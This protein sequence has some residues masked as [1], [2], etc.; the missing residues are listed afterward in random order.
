MEIKRVILIILDGFGVGALPDAKEYK[1][2]GAN[3]LTHIYETIPDFNLPNMSALGIYK[4]ITNYKLPITN[5]ELIGSY[6]KMA[7]RSKGKDTTTGHWEISG[8]ILEEPFPT[9]PNGFPKE[10]IDSY[11][12]LIGKKTIG[13]FPCSGTEILKLLGEEHC[14]TGYPIIYTSADS[15]FQIAENET[16]VPLQELYKHCEIAREMLGN[17]PFEKHKVGRVIA[18]PFVGNSKENF[19]RTENRRDYSIK[20][21]QPT[22]LDYIKNS[23]GKVIGIGKIEDIFANQGL[24][25]SAHTTNN[26]NGIQKIIE[27]ITSPSLLTTHYS[28][29]FVNLVDFDMLWGHRRAVK[30]YYDGLKYFDDNLPRIIS[31]L[32]E[33]DLLIITSDHGNDP[34]FL[35]HTDHTREYVPLLIYSK[36]KNFVRG[37]NLGIRETFADIAKT[38]DEL[39]G[40]KKIS[41]G[42]SFV[43]EIFE[44]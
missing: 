32:K 11:E 40:L 38:V 12:K 44:T 15:V 33:T 35:Q 9:Y 5:R 20:P 25:E 41:V 17:P 39:F 30:E 6:G 23:G 31:E 13:N 27:Y 26:K 18:R 22:I 34:T 24:T 28:L 29:I 7:E 4:L 21:F 16:V 3:T 1:D 10:I 43:K 42:K 2:D 14:K 36:N 8:I 37:K 19:K